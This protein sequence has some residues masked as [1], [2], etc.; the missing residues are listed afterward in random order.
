MEKRNKKKLFAIIGGSVLAFVLTI[1][2]SV[3]ITLAYF[4]QTA[5]KDMTVSMDA[6]ITVGHSWTDSQTYSTAVLPGEAINLT[7]KATLDCGTRGAFLAAKVTLTG[8][9]TVLKNTSFAIPEN[10]EWYYDAGT[11]YIYYVGTHTGTPTA[12]A[13]INADGDKTLSGGYIVNSTINND[14]RVASFTVTLT[15]YA[16]Q[17]VVFD[18]TSGAEVT[19]TFANV[20][21]M[22]EGLPAA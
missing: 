6:A 9:D 5:G 14:T 17:G 2:L 4:G 16:V 10:S 12:P 3:S 1:A 11:Q 21:A 8:A 20:S 7:A 15:F 22:F 13:V 18:T 19:P